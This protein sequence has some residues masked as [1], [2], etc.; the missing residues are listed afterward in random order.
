[1]PYEAPSSITD[2]PAKQR[3]KLQQLLHERSVL[4]YSFSWRALVKVLDAFGLKE[5]E[6]AVVLEQSIAAYTDTEERKIK[7]ELNNEIAAIYEEHGVKSMRD[8]DPF[9]R[10]KD[11]LY[12]EST[13]TSFS[14]DSAIKIGVSRYKIPAKTMADIF[15]AATTRKPFV[16][17][18]VREVKE[19][20]NGKEEE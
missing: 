20:G 12:F 16:T 13:S 17:L 10:A 6:V 5:E 4:G 15:E 9:G 11:Y 1:M 2:I 19:N 7:D 18:Q 3:R 8:T 14:K